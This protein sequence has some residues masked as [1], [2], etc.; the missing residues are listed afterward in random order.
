MLLRHPGVQL[1]AVTSRQNAGR[2]LAQVFPRF[3]SQP[4]ARRLKFIQPDVTALL[5][6]I[7]PDFRRAVVF[8][9]LPHGV[10][11]EWAAPLVAAGVRTIDLSADFRMRSAAVYQEFYEHQHPAPA[12]LK[13]AVYG[14]PEVRRAAIRTARLV[15]SPGCY[16]TSVLLPLIPLLRA[17]LV[18]S[19]GLI[20]DSLSGVSGAGRKAEEPWLF[21]ECHGSARAYG[22]PKHRHLAEMEQELGLAAGRKV[23]L[24][25]TPHL[26]PVHRGILTTIYAAPARRRADFSKAV[27]ACL[28]RAYARE[29]FVRLLEGAA[30]PDLKN[31]VETNFIEIAHRVDPRTGRLILLSAEDNLTKGAA[32]QAVQSMNIMLGVSE[33]M[34]LL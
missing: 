21:C 17:G 15:A 3:A 14:L 28:R 23:V 25:F 1:E 19:R 26:I 10:A 9:A 8:L 11:A 30:L 31:I 24:Q 7:G 29:P 13:K 32:G 16:P 27:D 18:S 22:L 4:V 6:Q 34:G 33:T 12:L 2:S 5:R 20:A